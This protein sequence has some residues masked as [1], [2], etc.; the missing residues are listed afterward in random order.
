M[1]QDGKW[2]VNAVGNLDAPNRPLPI[3]LGIRIDPFKDATEHQRKY[4]IVTFHSYPSMAPTHYGEKCG[5]P[6]RHREF[7]DRFK[8]VEGGLRVPA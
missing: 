3:T 5:R 7:E 1:F 4:G 2:W 8:A 6:Y